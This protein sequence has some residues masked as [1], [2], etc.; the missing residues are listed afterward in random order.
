MAKPGNN[1][2]LQREAAKVLADHRNFLSLGWLRNH[3]G[4]HCFLDGSTNCVMGA[5]WSDSSCASHLPLLRKSSAR[6]QVH[7]PSCRCSSTLVPCR[8][9]CKIIFTMGDMSL[10]F[11]NSPLKIFNLP[12]VASRSAA[13]SISPAS[14][15]SSGCAVPAGMLGSSVSLCFSHRTQRFPLCCRHCAI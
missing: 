6:P 11:S 12:L 10:K 5:R 14:I 15:V 3:F 1:D 4:F 13:Q 9:K 7:A 2:G 8:Q